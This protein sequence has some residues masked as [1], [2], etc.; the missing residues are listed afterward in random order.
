MCPRFQTKKSWWARSC[1]C[2]ARRP[3]CPGG[4]RPGRSLQLFACQSPLLLEARSWTPQGRPGPAGKSSRRVA[5]PAPQPRKQL[6]LELQAASA[7]RGGEEAEAPAPGPQQPPPPDLRVWAS[8]GGADPRAQR[9]LFVFSRSQR[10][11]LFAE[12]REQ[13]GGDRV[14]GPGARAPRGQGPPPPSGIPDA[15]PW[16]PSPGRRRQ[17]H[18]LRQPPRQAAWQEV[19]LQLQQEAPARE[20]QG[21]GLGRLDYRAPGVRGLPLRGR[22]RLPAAA[23]TWSPPTTPSSRR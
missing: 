18:G 11:T 13:L 21:A 19:R 23:R 3:L 15:G 10:K 6:C 14:V 2:F 7:S 8:A 17:R 5:G 20:L 22:V 9:L 16:S 12:M 4:R 1:G